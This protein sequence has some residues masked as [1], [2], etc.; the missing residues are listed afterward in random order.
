MH[1][2]STG[3]P[4]LEKALILK[5]IQRVSSGPK[6]IHN[7]KPRGD[8]HEAVAIRIGNGFCDRYCSVWISEHLRSLHNCEGVCLCS[9]QSVLNPIVPSHQCWCHGYILIGIRLL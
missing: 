7:V 3:P 2:L 5:C 1:N 6:E 8:V 4:R 9:S